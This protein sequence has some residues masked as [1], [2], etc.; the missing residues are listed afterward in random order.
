MQ[1]RTI[2]STGTALPVIGCGTWQGFD[3]GRDAAAQAGRAEVL[4]ALFAAGGSVIDSSPMYGTSEEVVGD[5]LAALGANGRAFLATK[6]WTRGRAAGIAQME[7]SLAR[8]RRERIELM[9]VHNLVDWEVHLDTLRGWQ[10]EGRVGHIGVTHY[11]PSAHDELERVL[12]AQPLDAVQ[13][14]Y[15]LEDRAAEARL[16]PLA[17]AKGIAVI[18]NRPFGGGELLRARAGRPLPA[19]AA[20]LGLDSWAALLLAF[21]LAHPAVT[22]VIP[23]TGRAAHM[24]ELLQAGD[25][26]AADPALRERLAAAL[27]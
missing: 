11:T 5:V 20:E 15:S 25:V 26:S 12:R 21:V 3:V 19:L 6:V 7:R 13:L 9:Q 24:R 14:D 2:P 8:L 10:R 17:Q 16:L 18:V 22:C 27:R 4:A 1:R 23:G